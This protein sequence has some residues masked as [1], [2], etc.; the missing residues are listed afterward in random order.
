MVKKI[1]L[2]T[3]IFIPLMLLLVFWTMPKQ[4]TGDMVLLPEEDT[5]AHNPWVDSLMA[6][7]TPDER[8]GQLIMLELSGK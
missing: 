1:I 2:R 8:I 5:S 3:L 4:S 7:M 6:A